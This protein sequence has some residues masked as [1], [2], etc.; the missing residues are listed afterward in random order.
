MEHRA[1]VRRRAIKSGAPP[2][3]RSGPNKRRPPDVRLSVL[4]LA[5]L[6]A[7]PAALGTALLTADPPEERFP[8]AG[9]LRVVAGD[10]GQP[11]IEAAG[12]GAPEGGSEAEAAEQRGE[13]GETRADF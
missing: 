1:V 8:A 12:D 9:G 3:G 11:E 10:P 7:A 2:A 13:E 6:F 4:L 5:A